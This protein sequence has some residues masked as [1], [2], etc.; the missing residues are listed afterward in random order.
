METRT[1]PMCCVAKVVV[2]F[3]GTELT[4][5]KSSPNTTKKLERMLHGI[6]ATEGD[7]L[8]VATTNNQQKAANEALT[9]LGFKHTKWMPKKKHP[10]T[11]LRMWWRP[12]NS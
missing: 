6:I 8:L 9:N 12:P 5:G 1:F 7:N 11:K 2:D 4:S 3:G 10:E